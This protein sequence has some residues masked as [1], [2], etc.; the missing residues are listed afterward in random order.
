MSASS[1]T[2]K[3]APRS[4]TVTIE[5]VVPGALE[6]VWE[7][8]TTKSGI[9]SWWGPSGF[10]TSVRRLDVREGGEFEYEMTV[11]DP[12][13]RAAMTSAGIPPTSVGHG[14]YTEVVP[15]ARLAYVNVVDFVPD[16]PPYENTVRVEFRAKGDAVA[17]TV[18]LDRLHNEEWTQ[19][20]VAG[21][22]SQFDRLE[23]LLAGDPVTG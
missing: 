10:T 19:M 8:W 6:E 9:E 13:Q 3:N 1:P 15:R 23:T 20:A 14:K 2:A 11:V 22:N 5:R 7:L 21:Y 17:F 16:T 12:G 18:I 4:E